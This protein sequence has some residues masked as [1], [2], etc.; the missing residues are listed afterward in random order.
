[1]EVLLISSLLQ[2]N[3]MGKCQGSENIPGHPRGELPTVQPQVCI[4][5]LHCAAERG[6]VWKRDKQHISKIQLETNLS[7]SEICKVRQD[8]LLSSRTGSIPESTLPAPSFLILDQLHT[9]ATSWPKSDCTWSQKVQSPS[10]LEQ[11]LSRQL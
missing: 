8:F 7:P 11:R 1:M 2:S 5:T 4:S 6:E 10:L 3:P 9:A